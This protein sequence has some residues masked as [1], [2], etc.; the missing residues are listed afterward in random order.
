MGHTPKGLSFV[1][2]WLVKKLQA[3]ITTLDRLLAYRRKNSEKQ[4]L[5]LQAR[6]QIAVLLD[7]LSAAA[8]VPVEEA[9]KTIRGLEGAACRVY[10]DVLSRLLPDEYQFDGRSRRPA[11]DIFNTFLNYGYGILYRQVEKAL[12]LAG[13]NPYT[14]FMHRDEYLRKAM[15]FDFKE[16]YRHWVEQ[17]VFSLFASKLPSLQHI[18]EKDNGYWLNDEGKRILAGN[19][20]E[21]FRKEREVEDGTTYT[22]ERKLLLEAKAFASVMNKTLLSWSPDAAYN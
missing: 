14:G 8:L 6:Q 21:S 18:M 13:V 5:I 19:Y 20:L 15:V 3:K 11:L 1:K 9:A 22:R 2:D 10:F 7:K 16:P 17:S 12:I 4:A